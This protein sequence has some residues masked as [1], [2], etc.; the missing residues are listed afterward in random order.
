MEEERI[1]LLELNQQVSE[2]IKRHLPATYWVVAE[3]SEIKI[4]RRGHCYLDLI[5]K[6]E[7]TEK[8]LAKA[9][10]I[11]WA[12]TYRM[13]EPYFK[14]TTGQEL[15][16]GLKILINASPEFHE[17]YGYSLFIHDI[18]PSFTLGE[19]AKQ[20]LETI[21]RL[22]DEG[23]FNMNKELPFPFVPQRI[24][25]ISSRN[26]AGYK[27]F[28][29]QLNNNPYGYTFYTKLFPAFMQG[30][31]VKSSIIH[32]LDKIY[33]YE[34]YFDVI[35]IIRGGG[36]QSDLS[37]FDHYELAANVAQFP[38]PVITGIGHEKDESVVDLIANTKLKTPTAV[39][40]FLVSKAYDFE[41]KLF[42]QRDQFLDFVNNYMYKKHQ[43]LDQTSYKLVP[44]AN[45]TVDRAK[46]KLNLINQ[47]LEHASKNLVSAKYNSLINKR[48]RIS[49]IA[50]AYI[51]QEKYEIASK[52]QQIENSVKTYI[53]NKHKSIE[54]LTRAK[55]YLDPQNVLKRG[56]SITQKDGEV[57]KDGESLEDEDVITSYFYKGKVE[58]KVIKKRNSGKEK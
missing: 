50:F 16:E 15:T 10:A 2:G 57:V 43:Y 30:D 11:I 49:N 55:S 14:T 22:E 38:L 8:I 26:A 5:E 18:E 13:L 21:K 6:D 54:N 4:N 44:L 46:H 3:I 32:C 58:S 12:S 23:I 28:M 27:D 17:L 42:Q 56:F 9:R 31:E 25:V 1:T 7:L 52:Q 19:L 37:Y 39:A 41:Q 20:K 29:E 53:K 48:Q 36:A 35:A 40:D 47:R 45:N 24:A 34:N 51:K 33:E